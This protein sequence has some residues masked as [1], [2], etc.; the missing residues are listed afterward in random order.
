MSGKVPLDGVIYERYIPAIN[1]TFFI[2]EMEGLR[3]YPEDI[4]KRDKLFTIGIWDH[5]RHSE[6][7]PPKLFAFSFDDQ[8]AMLKAVTDVFVK[9]SQRVN[10]IKRFLE[11]VNG[12]F[13][14][15]LKGE[16]ENQP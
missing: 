4:R 6:E 9:D 11:K 3:S 16:D 15:K 5:D 1:A 13:Q 7:D 8:A 10:M 12:Y 14:F 2:K